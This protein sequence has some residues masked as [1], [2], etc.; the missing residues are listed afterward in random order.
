MNL[1]NEEKRE[2]AKRRVFFF[3]SWSA[4]LKTQ[5]MSLAHCGQGMPVNYQVTVNSAALSNKVLECQYY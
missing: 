3:L 4:C 1:S 2:E 5:D